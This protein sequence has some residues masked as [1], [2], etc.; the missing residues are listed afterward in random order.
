MPLRRAGRVPLSLRRV[1]VPAVTPSTAHQQFNLVI[2]RH[3]GYRSM[4]VTRVEYVVNPPLVHEFE[5]A[6]EVCSLSDV[7]SI[8]L[9]ARSFNTRAKLIRTSSRFMA[10]PTLQS[11]TSSEP[12]S[13]SVAWVV[14]QAMTAGMAQASI[15]GEQRTCASCSFALFVCWLII[16]VIAV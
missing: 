9:V 12:I 10:H 11:T 2:N 6:L 15:S 7:V 8:E 13:I 1:A 5:D 3:A 4:A 16:V 14:S